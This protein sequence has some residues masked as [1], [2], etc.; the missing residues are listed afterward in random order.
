M[1]RLLRRGRIRRPDLD[2]LVPTRVN[3]R[4]EYHLHR[5]LGAIRGD[6]VRNRTYYTA[7]LALAQARQGDLELACHTGDQAAGL[8]AKARGSKR[9]TEVLVGVK[10]LVTSSGSREAGMREGVERAQ[11]W[12]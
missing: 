8:L 4:A 1:D 9:S 11:A 12:I 7:Y 6:L 10:K 5:A 3:D 2:R